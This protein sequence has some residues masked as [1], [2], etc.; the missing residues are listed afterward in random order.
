[1]KNKIDKSI[2]KSK[3]LQLRDILKSEIGKLH[4]GSKFYTQLEVMKKYNLSCATVSRAMQELTEAGFLTR[5]TGE[6]TFV[7]SLV[8]AEKDTNTRETLFLLFPDMSVLCDLNPLNWFI[9]SEILKGI[10]CSYA[11]NCQFISEKEFMKKPDQY[12]KLITMNPSEKNIKLLNSEKIKFITINQIQ[13]F[14][15]DF[16]NVNINHMPGIFEAVAYL[17]KELGQKKIAII[18]S[19]LSAHSDRIAAFQIGIK[20]FDLHVPEYFWVKAENGRPEGGYNAM[21][22]L[23][24]LKDPPTA[25]FVDTDIKAS[26]AINAIRDEGLSVPDDISIIGF[27]DI[28]DAMKMNPPLTT[29]SG[30]YFEMGSEAIRLLEK[31]YVRKLTNI[32]SVTINTKLIIRKSCKIHKEVEYEKHR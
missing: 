14:A 28:P 11:G 17:V 22:K 18:T 10:F 1:M 29:V 32:P 23:L 16:N 8:P 7:K 24:N 2:G 25:V 3:Y 19:D 6:G 27:D 12:G 15:Q 13:K 9:K 21:K 31:K 5:K 26:G 4:A 20:T 30:M